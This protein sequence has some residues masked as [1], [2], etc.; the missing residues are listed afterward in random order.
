[1]RRDSYE[2]TVMKEYINE[3]LKQYTENGK[4]PWHMPGHKRK[5][6]GDDFF[7]NMMMRD[8][9]EAR[10]LDDMHDPELFMKETLRELTELYGT[11]ATYM[12]VNGSTGGVLAAIYACTNYG[13]HII[14]ARNCHKSV[15]NAITING[16]IPHYIVSDVE[17]H[18]I[19]MAVDPEAVKAEVSGLLK[20]GI[21]P[22]AV[23]ITSP[24]YEGIISDISAIKA[25][26]KSACG[27]MMK[28]IPPNSEND[29]EV[30]DIPLI[31]D[32]AHGAH[33]PFYNRFCNRI[34]ESDRDKEDVCTD[35]VSGDKLD[36]AGRNQADI[37]I[38]STH[39]TL[40]AL[41]QTGL[42]HVNNEKYVD[43]LEKYLKIFQSSSPSYLFVQS[44]EKAVGYALCNPQTWVRYRENIKGFRNKMSGLKNM[45]LFEPHEVHDDTRLVIFTDMGGRKLEQILDDRYGLV[46]EMA[47][48]SYVIL[49][50]SVMDEEKDFDRLFAALKE[51][52]HEEKPAGDEEK[53]ERNK[54]RGKLSVPDMKWSPSEAEKS[55]DNAELVRLSE[56]AG[57]IAME[58]VFAYPP[59]IPVVV[60]GEVI[61]EDVISRIQEMV[62][63]GLN[64]TGVH[65][66][67]KE[68]EIY[69][70]C[71]KEIPPHLPLVLHSNI[72]YNET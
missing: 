10:G 39:K 57:M 36:V 52:D 17:S 8:F 3:A 71:A 34:D 9:T 58:Y 56:A 46:V 24:T 14:V 67:G 49:I 60:P 42:I 6:I 55:A 19:C 21:V 45:K 7:D 15:Y 51:I 12:M 53:P 5:S 18:G 37:Y 13:D 50:T 68:P 69:L 59:G 16:L 43:R 29:S 61:C 25:A 33:L 48:G 47:A 72:C 41:T 70:E 4:Y 28:T 64:M 20:A 38:E 65:F 62:D 54:V 23:V 26:I 11:K 44:I 31:V 40:P 32:G 66:A 35:V 30:P 27:L 63:A 1:M 2:G 22:K